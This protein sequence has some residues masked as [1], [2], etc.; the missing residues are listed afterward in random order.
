MPAVLQ[1]EVMIA[2]AA[3]QFDDNLQLT[4]PVSRKLIGELLEQLARLVH[5]MASPDATAIGTGKS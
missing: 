4:N 1:P 3:D 2:N 5:L